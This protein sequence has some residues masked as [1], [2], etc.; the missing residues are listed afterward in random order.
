MS[1]QFCYISA[2]KVDPLYSIEKLCRTLQ[3]LTA[4]F[5]SGALCYQRLVNQ[6]MAIEWRSQPPRVVP[7][8][9]VYIC[10]YA[11]NRRECVCVCVFLSLFFARFIIYIRSVPRTA[12]A[13]R[14]P[15]RCAFCS[16]ATSWI[17]APGAPRQV[18]PRRGTTR[19]AGVLM[20]GV[21]VT[22]FLV[23][24]PNDEPF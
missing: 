11:M 21:A 2:F 19:A 12:D 4:R 15:P 13:C 3:G 23:L 18:P 10:I 22:C 8:G 1:L 6:I 24:Q 9:I 7:R 17:V 20:C 5:Y 14:T 16:T